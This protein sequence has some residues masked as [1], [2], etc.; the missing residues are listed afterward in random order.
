MKACRRLP[1]LFGLLLLAAPAPAAAPPGPRDAAGDPLPPAAR[2]RLGTT[3]W[4]QQWSVVGLG[5]STDGKVLACHSYEEGIGL[6]DAVTG[7]KLR[8]LYS[9]DDSRPM[10]VALSADGKRVAGCP[11]RGAVQ[12]W[13]VTT[14]KPCGQCSLG[15][16]DS[17][18][19]LVL[20]PDGSHLLTVNS[21]SGTAQVWDVSTGAERAGFPRNA[22]AAVFG[23]EGKTVLLGNDKRVR[24]WDLATGKEVRRLEGEARLLAISRDGRTLAARGKRSIRLWDPTTGEEKRALAVPDELLHVAAG[25]NLVMSADGRTVALAGSG[26]LFAWDC[27]TGKE[28]FRRLDRSWYTTVALS[29]DGQTLF[30]GVMYVPVVHRWGL[31]AGRALFPC[32]AH[33]NHV[34]G[35]AFAPDGKALASGATDRTVRLWERGAAG[36]WG[37]GRTLPLGE[38]PLTVLGGRVAWSSDGRLLAMAQ[39]GEVCLR[40]AKTGKVVRTLTGAKGCYAVAFSPDG[41]LLAVGDGSYGTSGRPNGRVL[42]WETATG[43]RTRTFEGHQNYVRSVAFSPDGKRLASG[44]DAV[45]VWDLSSGKQVRRFPQRDF[46]DAL[47]FTRDGRALVAGGEEAVVWDLTSGEEL[48]RLGGEHGWV[49]GVALSPDGRRLATTG[50]D[51][52]VR[53]W[54][55]A[56]GKEL[57]ELA[58]HAGRAYAV[59]FSPDGQTL[60][61]AGQDTT[62]LLWDVPEAVRAGGAARARLARAD[63]ERLWGELG[64]ADAPAGQQ[65]VWALVDDPAVAVPFL[66]DKLGKPDQRV[67]GARVARL[68]ADLDAAEFARREA[69]SKELDKLGRA[70]VPALRAALARKPSLEVVR[71]IEALLLAHDRR[72]ILLPA[73]DALRAARAL[74][75]LETVGTPEARKLLEALAKGPPTQQSEDARKALERLDRRTG[76]RR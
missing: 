22:K 39:S 5:C 50:S 19:G 72:S 59:A 23:A 11:T 60:A 41:K 68:I 62:V 1:I 38:E 7:R 66:R 26:H 24:I 64:K 35:L 8:H 52:L 46:I 63:L 15:A 55:F 25:E 29:P 20:S 34:Q 44:S 57:A 33:E 17:P 4:R 75:V 27:A 49:A 9:G 51:G 58:G 45:R 67:D 3:R 40:D 32:P 2:A 71:R 14:G 28:R 36:G 65:A 30:W 21:W 61:S 42:V 73:G 13:D 74:Q 43:R 70:A 12:V 10:P 53:L 6:F 16:N 76:G 31:S 18:T 54:D 37:G 48:H 56:T 69:A 47:A